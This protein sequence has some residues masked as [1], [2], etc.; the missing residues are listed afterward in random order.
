MRINRLTAWLARRPTDAARLALYRHGVGLEELVQ[1][2]PASGLPELQTETAAMLEMAAQ[3][4][5]NALGEASKYLLKWCTQD[6]RVLLQL[7]IPR[8]E[9]YR[10][11]G[12]IARPED[13]VPQDPAQ[14]AVYFLAQMARHKEVDQ[15]AVYA[16]IRHSQDQMQQVISQLAEDRKSMQALVFSLINLIAQA[17]PL[18]GPRQEEGSPIEDA[19]A[20]AIQTATEAIAQHVMPQLGQAVGVGV[21]KLASANGRASTKA[22]KLKKRA[23]KKTQT[24]GAT[25]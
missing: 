10:D 23:S 6:G 22:S 3:T 9:A 8:V 7:V 19:K 2:W 4:D 5:A 21:K 16:A 20:L 1:E 17:S 14:A 25:S 13:S 24:N 18:Q 15:R 11:D 12:T